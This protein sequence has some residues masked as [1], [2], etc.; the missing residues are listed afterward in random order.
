MPRILGQLALGRLF[1]VVFWWGLSGISR[2]SLLHPPVCENLPHVLA[3]LCASMCYHP[4]LA[5]GFVYASCT[6]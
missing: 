6:G 1:V 2:Q 4:F 3:V 5:A